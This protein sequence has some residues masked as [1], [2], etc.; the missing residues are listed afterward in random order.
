MSTARDDFPL[1]AAFADDR[2][3][4]H[5]RVLII[6][7][8]ESTAALD[9]IDRLRMSLLDALNLCDRKDA[10]IERLKRRLVM[11]ANAS[12]STPSKYIT[13]DDIDTNQQGAKE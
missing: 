13:V 6:K 11:G 9:E 1:L 3:S 8:R 10:D 5:D 7:R 4:G 2:A 12:R